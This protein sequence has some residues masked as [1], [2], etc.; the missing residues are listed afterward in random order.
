MIKGFLTM[1]VDKEEQKIN[2]SMLYAAT[3]NMNR[4]KNVD[5]LR[6]IFDILDVER[7]DHICYRTVCGSIGIDSEFYLE[8]LAS[9]E[10]EKESI[11]FKIFC[12]SL[13]KFII[14]KFTDAFAT[15]GLESTSKMPLAYYKFYLGSF[16][17]CPL[18]SEI[19]PLFKDFEHWMLNLKNTFAGRQV[20]KSK[21]KN[22]V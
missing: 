16:K 14:E 4:Q 15:L 20:F 3:L 9:K 13:R 5:Y 10:W 17:F 21:E 8:I 18:A 11:D 6:S 1:K 2:R 12:K 7:K 22:Q 19:D